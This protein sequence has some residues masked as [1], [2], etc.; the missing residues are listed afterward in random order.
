[1]INAAIAPCDWTDV[2]EGEMFDEFV[3]GP[4]NKNHQRDIYIASSTI[5]TPPN[6]ELYAPWWRWWVDGGVAMRAESVVRLSHFSPTFVYQMWD[7][8]QDSRSE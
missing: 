2:A 1:M 7:R 5:A 4:T 8:S 3:D 6:S